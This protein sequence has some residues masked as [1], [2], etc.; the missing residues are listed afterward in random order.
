[1]PISRKSLLV[2]P[3]IFYLLI[4]LIVFKLLFLSEFNSRYAQEPDLSK[5]V[6]AFSFFLSAILTLISFL[7]LR[8]TN[9]NE[10]GRAYLLKVF[11]VPILIPIIFFAT[12]YLFFSL[13]N[14]IFP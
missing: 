14:E 6:K 5:P 4:Y 1:M 10:L 2:V 9:K 12:L 3:L 13:F 7:Y 11:V 8:N